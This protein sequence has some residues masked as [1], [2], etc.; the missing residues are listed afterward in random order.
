MSPIVRVARL[1]FLCQI[2]Q[3][4][5]FLEV[6]GIKK[7]VWLVGLFSSIFGFFWRQFARAIRLLSCFFKDLSESVISLS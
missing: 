1:F 6:V 2:S 7:F 5:L 3:I 4:W